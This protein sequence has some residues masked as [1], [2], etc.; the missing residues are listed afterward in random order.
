MSNSRSP[1]DEAKARSMA[2]TSSTP[3]T[4]SQMVFANGK[5]ILTWVGVDDDSAPRHH[6]YQLNVGVSETNS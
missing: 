5:E 3:D 4:M 1:G 6:Y 2:S